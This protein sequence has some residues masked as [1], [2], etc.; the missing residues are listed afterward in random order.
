L[1]QNIGVGERIVDL[2]MAPRL[3]FGCRTA[4]AGAV[5]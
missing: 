3:A 5:S 2:N 4:Q 1:R